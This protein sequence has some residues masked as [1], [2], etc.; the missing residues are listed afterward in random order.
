MN[1]LKTLVNSYFYIMD[2]HNQGLDYIL[3]N[4]ISFEK[5]TN[6]LESLLKF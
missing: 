4:L 2:L 3:Q 5:L 1:A 6:T